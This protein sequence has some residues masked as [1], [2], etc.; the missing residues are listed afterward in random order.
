MRGCKTWR[1]WEARRKHKR[2]NFSPTQGVKPLSQPD[3]S[4]GDCRDNRGHWRDSLLCYR[5]ALNVRPVGFAEIR[6]LQLIGHTIAY[7]LCH[8]RQVPPFLDH[9]FLPSCTSHPWRVYIG[10]R[11]QTSRSGLWRRTGACSQKTS[12]RPARLKRQ[13]WSVLYFIVRSPPAWWY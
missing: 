12:G 11:I 6:R 3:A 9:S 1:K 4:L 2:C 7:W 8:G 13:S 5:F 10:I